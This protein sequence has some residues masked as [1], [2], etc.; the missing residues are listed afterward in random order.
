MPVFDSLAPATSAN[1]APAEDMRL[2]WALQAAGGGA[3]DW[4]FSRDAAWWSD[5]MYDLWGVGRGLPINEALMAANLHEEDRARVL[6]I[7][8]ACSAQGLP[9]FCE[10]R[11]RHPVRGERWM[12]SHGRPQ[13]DS[14]GVAGRI[15]GLT[16]DITESKEAELRQLQLMQELETSESEA[17][18]QQTLFQSVFECSPDSILLIDEDRMIVAINS[19][20]TKVIGYT[21]DELKGRSTRCLYAKEEDWQTTGLKLA[22]AANQHVTVEPHLLRKNGEIFPCRATAAAIVDQSGRRLGFV[23]IIRDVTLEQSRERALREKQ[24]LEALGRLTGGIAHDFNNLLTVI[25]GHLQLLELDAVND[26]MR[27][28]IGAAIGAADMGARLNQRLITFA[29]QRRLDPKPVDLNALVRSLLDLV[30]RSIGESIRVTITLSASPAMVS[31]DSS[32]MENAVLN[33][34]LNAR[35]AMPAGGDLVIETSHKVIGSGD[36]ALSGNITP[37]DYV[38]MS[39]SDSGIG[40]TPEVMSHAFE[41][42]FTT[43][44]VGKGT[45][46]GLTTIHGF[47]QQSGG[48]IYLES[49]HGRGTNVRIL[50]PRA[51]GETL[52]S[53]GRTLR[54]DP[55]AGSGQR[56]LVVED[57]RDVRSVT[58]ERLKRLNYRV[59]EADSANTA[60]RII[61]RGEPVDLVFSDVVMPGGMSGFDLIDRLRNDYPHLRTLLVSGFPDNLERTAHGDEKQK[62]LMK[63]YSSAELA[64]AIKEALQ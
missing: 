19:T 42:Y 48:H 35:D 62:I 23:A 13:A 64:R 5:E 9:Y 57:N 40:M 46:L 45:G 50:L 1:L 30:C 34:A 36:I 52:A 58:L 4:D 49:Q 20:F 12:A 33:L 39:V 24:G 29:R 7:L 25:S 6:Q 11:I 32:E 43:K 59:I 51:A 22:G 18:R 27:R 44:E 26:D 53:T 17:R 38:L 41:P 61:Q 55:D 54:I 8:R 31:I 10:F 56:I 63:P 3:W 15:L 47:I 14:A 37:G 21:V 16:F 60:L 2:R 28:H